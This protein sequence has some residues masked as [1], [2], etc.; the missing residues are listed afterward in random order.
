MNC[1]EVIALRQAVQRIGPLYGN[2]IVQPVTGLEKLRDITLWVCG[3]VGVAR[4]GYSGGCTSAD[5][6]SEKGESEL[7]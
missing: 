7:D 4:G 2:T 3:A 1:W 5:S 6:L